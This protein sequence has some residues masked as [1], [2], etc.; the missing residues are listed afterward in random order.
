MNRSGWVLASAL[1]LLTVPGCQGPVT[2]AETPAAAAPSGRPFKPPVLR[3]LS[4]PAGLPVGDAILIRIAGDAGTADLK[5][6]VFGVWAAG[7]G[8]IES[9]S[10]PLPPKFRRRARGRIEIDT[11][12]SLAFIHSPDLERLPLEIRVQF[13]DTAGRLSPPGVHR[14]EFDGR[15]RGASPD[16]PPKGTDDSALL[17]VIYLEVYPLERNGSGFLRGGRLRRR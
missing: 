16:S 3:E 11:L 8:E 4:G 10:F 12:A 9:G 13:R 14:F 7:R 2:K 17:G 1:A 5:E 6:V 15:A